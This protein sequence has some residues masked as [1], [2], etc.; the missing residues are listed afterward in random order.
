M[1]IL[2]L[3]HALNFILMISLGIGVGAFLARRFG[4]GWRLWWLGAATFVFSQV[5]HIPFNSLLNL[6]VRQGVLPWPAI[7][8][9]ALLASAIVGGLSAG[10][11]EEVSRYLVL[12]FWV[13]DARSWRKGVLYGAGHGGMEAILLGLLAAYGYL[14]LMALRG[15]EL[16][17]VVPAA[18]LALAQ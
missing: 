7:R 3:T 16:S 18:Q 13:K 1:N 10:V 9:Q 12:R 2:V 4:L 14:Q 11:F 6:L 8:S 17:K 5:F 15:V